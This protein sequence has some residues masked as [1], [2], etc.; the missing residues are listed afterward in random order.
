V[1][2]PETRFTPLSRLLHWTMAA[3]ILSM[4]FVGVG[5][6]SSTTERYR[7]LLA[8]HRPLGIAILILA[9]ARLTNRLLN[10]PPPLPT[11]LPRIQQMAATVSHILLYGLMFIMPLLGWAMLS[12]APYPI[13]LFGPLRLPAILSPDPVLYS[14]LRALHTDFALLFYAVIL[15]HLGAALMHAWIRRDAVFRSMAGGRRRRTP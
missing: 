14:Q 15:V 9:V 10:P 3:M 7:Y 2:M 5:M 1:N 12:A 6:V 8:L 4:L 11:S 13:V